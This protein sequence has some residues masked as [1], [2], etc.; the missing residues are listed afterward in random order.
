MRGGLEDLIA[1]DIKNKTRDQDSVFQKKLDKRVNNW[2]KVRN[3]EKRAEKAL[4]LKN[5]ID[6]TL[7][8]KFMNNSRKFS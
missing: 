5:K 3:Q 4:A 6:E 2:I 7:D 1:R 8:R